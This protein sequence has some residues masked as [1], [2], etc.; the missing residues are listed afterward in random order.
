MSIDLAEK[1]KDKLTDK[2][3]VVDGSVPE[4]KRFANWT[5]KVKTVNMN[6]RAL[7]EFDGPVDI[8]WYDI[9]PA[10]LTV[11]DAPVKRAAPA[12]VAK[13]PAS[14][15]APA[16][17]PAAPAGKSPLD[18]IRAQQAATKPAA[19]SG[20]KPSPLDMIR[21]QQA[22][23]AKPESTEPAPE[24]VAAPVETVAAVE[25]VPAPVAPTPKPAAPTTGPDGRPLSKLDMI[26][27][28][29]AAKQS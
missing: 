20:A 29:G 21:K 10:Y 12:P 18:A 4:L 25:P 19:A 5:G 9:D 15:A 11:V 23:K 7:V 22:A 6:C 24:S 1:L 27:M 16:A 28:Q 14:A 2:F 13:A 3:V 26:R 8:S 17:K